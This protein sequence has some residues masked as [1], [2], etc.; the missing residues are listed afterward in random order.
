MKHYL[1]T[2]YAHIKEF[3]IFIFIITYQLVPDSITNPDSKL[4]QY[5]EM[6]FVS[7][8]V[9]YMKPFYTNIIYRNDI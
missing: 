6:L 8:Y 7:H 1:K 9:D 5:Y 2:S 3:F 4:F